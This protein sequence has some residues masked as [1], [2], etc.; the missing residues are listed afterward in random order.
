MRTMT[1]MERRIRLA[2]LQRIRGK[3]R[4][5][6]LFLMSFQLEDEKFFFFSW[7]VGKII[8]AQHRCDTC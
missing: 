3:E 7:P 8:C 6:L 1:I 2:V 4:G 5:W